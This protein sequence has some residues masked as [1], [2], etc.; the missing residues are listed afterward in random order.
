MSS[1]FVILPAEPAGT[2]TEFSYL[3][4]PDGRTAGAHG[5]AAAAL[6]PPVGG[7]GAEVIAVVP[8]AALSW[9]RV[10]LPKGVPPGSPRLRAVLEG[11][12]EDQLLDEPETLHFALEPQPRAGAPVWVAV[13]QRAWLRSALQVLEAAGRPVTRL[14][15]EFAP[16]APPALHVLGEPKAALLA[17][18]G[19]D[20]VLLLPLTTG[21]LAMLPAL[22]DEALCFAEP[23]TDRPRR[24]R[25]S[26][27]CSVRSCCKRRRSA[28]CRRR[29]RDGTWRSS[30]SPARAG[31]ASSRRSPP[32]GPKCCARRSGGPRD[33]PRCCW[34]RPT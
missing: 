29:N 5:V 16:E 24:P 14:V 11:V 10:E 3:V 20:G 27:F 4:S 15:P 8:A 9:H 34:S 17:V 30:S 19:A 31:R 32:P 2:S 21:A 1:L 22:P 28:G 13:C 25:P 23:A 18:S 6:L 7:A 26:S 12:L 33:G